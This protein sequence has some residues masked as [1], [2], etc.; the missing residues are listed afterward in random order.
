MAALRSMYWSLAIVLGLLGLSLHSIVIAFPMEGAIVKLL[1]APIF[2]LIAA[3]AWGWKGA[4]WAGIIGLGAFFPFLS[5]PDDGWGNISNVIQFMLWYLWH[6]LNSSLRANF[7]SWWNHPIAAQ[8]T[9]L[10]IE[11]VTT[12]IILPYFI[13]LNP[14]PWAVNAPTSFPESLYTV[15][16]IKNWLNSLLLVSIVHGALCLP[17]LRRFVGRPD[18]G[19]ASKFSVRILL[20][21]ILG[22]VFLGM[23][24]K[25]LS[26]P[27]MGLPLEWNVL[28]RFSPIDTLFHTLLFAVSVFV[29]GIMARFVERKLAKEIAYS[30]DLRAQRQ[31]SFFKNEEL[32]SLLS[33]LAHDL[34]S[35]LVNIH[36]FAGELKEQL[37][38]LQSRNAL[39]DSYANL[40]KSVQFIDQGAERLEE[41]ISGVLRISRLGKGKIQMI[42][43]NMNQLFH[44]GISNLESQIV[45]T[46]ALIDIKP[47]QPCLGDPA[48]VGQV[49]S[50]L[51]DNALKYSKKEFPPHIT[52]HSRID[53]DSIVYFIR[54][55]GIGVPDFLHKRIFEP[56]YRV[57][58]DWHETGEGL[59]LSICKRLIGI[60]GGRLW[61][62]NPVDSEGGSRFC[63]SLPKEQEKI[64]PDPEVS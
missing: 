49:I 7:R 25:V 51:L 4:M 45:K 52:V 6:G 37:H 59:G 3:I 22:G 1:I 61:I 48:F 47:L 12:F 58:P 36:G 44:Q 34:R 53:D 60:M 54:D 13:S 64:T 11:L 31:E 5:W 14:A 39:N 63:F 24:M 56:S 18:G 38:S 28:W 9:F 23:M 30:A 42:P 40:L 19:N 41:V 32:E 55:R 20:L 35:P 16:L 10:P 29:G 62:E 27:M 33:V 46:N 50:N 26:T 57:Y 15:F 17:S 21:A 43:L 2:P 8:V